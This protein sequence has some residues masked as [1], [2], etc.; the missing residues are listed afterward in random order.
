MRDLMPFIV[1][2][3]AAGS[4]YG[5]AGMGLVLTYKTSGIFN[6]AHGAVAAAAAYL[7]YELHE[8]QGLPWPVAIVISVVLFAGVASVILERLARALRDV[9][10]AMRIVATI[11]MLL[12][13]Q[14]VAIIRYGPQVIPMQPFLPTD[15]TTFFDVTVGYDQMITFFVGLA[16]AIG[17]YAFFRF[18]RLG[19]GMRAVVDDP[20]LL[21]LNRMSPVRVRRWA[22]F[23]GSAFAALSG[24]LIAPTLGLEAFI[25]TLLVVQ[26]FGAA[27]VGAFSSLP[28]TYVGGLAVG[29]GAS[30]IT[31][32]VADVS[33]LR[34]LPSSFPFLVLFVVLLVLPRR[35]LVEAPVALAHRRP[36]ASLVPPRV[37]RTGLAAGLAVAL[38]VPWVVGT[39]L[40]VYTNAVIYVLVFLSLRL[41]VRTSN[42]VSLAH[43]GFAAVGAAGFAHF[44]DFGLP[45]PVALMAAGLVTVPVGA[46]VAIP[47]IRMSGL[48]L[49]I[50]TFGFNV[51]L[52][53]IFYSQDI[54]FGPIE[55]RHVPRPDFGPF[56]L[57]G[58]RGFYYV[59]LA[60]AVLGCVLIAAIHRTRLGRLLSGLADSPTALVTHGANTRVTLVLVFC[61]SAFMAGV[62]GGLFGSLTGSID[63][64]PFGPF[65][66]VLWLATLAIA[67]SGLIVPAFVA[68][69]AIAVVPSYISGFTDWQPVV[70]GVSAIGVA[71]A[72]GK[73]SPFAGWLERAAAAS[74]GRAGR[75]PAKARL[76]TGTRPARSAAPAAETAATEEVLV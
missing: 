23:L 37:A 17:L 8:R 18:S 3:L 20:D 75:D 16:A 65:T 44:T 74:E 73:D 36:G 19:L 38:A 56:D 53:Q 29:I 55:S 11:G 72:S 13:I 31:K 49:A 39:K 68:G 61:I 22:W 62:A 9:S 25:L 43:A 21:A 5:I 63:G 4:V 27:A 67:G 66:S 24:V 54:M 1:V 15:G 30:V 32:F 10:L 59:I 42:Q 76:A 52:E 71:I 12:A 7:F 69:L 45:W 33:S 64:S 40:P 47:A 60:I 14:G 58:D 35:L 26:A 46:L 34:G 57:S 41:L 2:G 51:L 6:F 48:Y 50:A 28:L 70:F